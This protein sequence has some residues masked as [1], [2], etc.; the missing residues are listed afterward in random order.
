MTDYRIQITDYR[1]T[2]LAA[3]LKSQISLLTSA[4][5]GSL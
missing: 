3:I 4:T 2:G 1:M 5:K